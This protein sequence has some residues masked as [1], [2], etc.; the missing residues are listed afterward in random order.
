MTLVLLAVKISSRMRPIAGSESEE[1]G[2]AALMSHDSSFCLGR[3]GGRCTGVN[4]NGRL[5]R[6]LFVFLV[7]LAISVINV[8]HLIC[9]LDYDLRCYERASLF[10]RL[11]ENFLS[12]FCSC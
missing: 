6:N 8:L 9:H 7:D 11:N 3:L 10:P 1:S 2:L 12:P 4:N 5:R